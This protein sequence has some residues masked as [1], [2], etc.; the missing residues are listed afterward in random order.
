MTDA[1][2]LAEKIS[3]AAPLA[4]AAAKEVMRET[5]AAGIED[6]YSTLRSGR[7]TAYRRMLDSEDVLEGPRAFADGRDPVWQGR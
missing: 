4:I 2:N 3:N 1:R 5:E 6:A 7:L